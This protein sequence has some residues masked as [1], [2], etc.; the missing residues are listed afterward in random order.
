MAEKYN[1]DDTQLIYLDDIQNI[2]LDVITKDLI[3]SV[4]EQG[5]ILNSSIL[6]KCS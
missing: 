2:L 1:T 6:K 5:Y 3:K 4:N